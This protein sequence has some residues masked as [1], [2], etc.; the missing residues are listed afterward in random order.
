MGLSTP[1]GQR[2]QRPIPPEGIQQAICYAIIDMGTHKEEWKGQVKMNQKVKICWEFPFLPEQVFDETKGPQRLSV[3]QDY[4]V[5]SDPKSNFMKALTKWRGGAVDIANDL[6][7]FI[8]QSCQL[9]ITH[10][11]KEGITYA[12]VD[13]SG[14]MVLPASSPDPTTGQPVRV[15]YGAPKNPTVFFDTDKF[16]WAAFQ[17]LWGFVQTKIKAS[18]EWPTLIQKYGPE[19]PTGQAPIAQPVNPVQPVAPVYAQQIVQQP[20]ATV[21][22]PM[23]QQQAIPAA[24]AQVFAPT[25]VVDTQMPQSTG[26]VVGNSNTPPAF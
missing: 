26:I 19:P 2:T 5:F 4:N 11:H 14:T 18:T 12:N 25:T 15:T 6:P 22:Q 3:M 8:G 13:S 24:Q 10:S 16:S 23:V 17:S 9:F 21:P 1:M 7:L 20:L